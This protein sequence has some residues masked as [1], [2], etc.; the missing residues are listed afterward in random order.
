[1]AENT[2]YMATPMPF[3]EVFTAVQT[4]VVD[5]IIGSGAEGYYASFRRWPY[6]LGGGIGYHPGRNN[7]CGRSRGSYLTVMDSFQS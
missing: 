6:C 4:G 3:S 7:R 5:G 2:G 1:M